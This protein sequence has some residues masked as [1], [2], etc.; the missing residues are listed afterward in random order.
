MTLA[1]DKKGRFLYTGLVTVCGN[2]LEVAIGVVV[3]INSDKGIALSW[4]FYDK[5]GT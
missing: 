3:V 1:A 4:D 2:V 5:Y